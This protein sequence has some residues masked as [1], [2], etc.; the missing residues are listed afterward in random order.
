MNSSIPSALITGGCGFIG[1]RLAEHLVES[2]TRVTLL[3]NSSRA[4]LDDHA[5]SLLRHPLVH[6]L[7][8]DL[9]E[10]PLDDVASLTP[11]HVFHLAAIVGV[12]NV[13][14]RPLDVLRTNAVTTSRLIDVLRHSDTLQRLVFFSTS[15]VH[16]GTTAAGALAFPTP[17]EA[18]LIL[19][20]LHHPRSSY[21]LSKIYGEALVH[22]SGLPATVLRPHNVYGPRMGAAHVIPELI[23]RIAAAQ[24]RQPLTITSPQYTRSFCHV[25]DAVRQI[26][27]AAHS[28][29]AVGRTFN[30]GND[31]EEITMLS[32]ARRIADV[33]G[34]HPELLPGEPQPHSPSRRCPDMT[35][36]RD[37]TGVGATIPLTDGLRATAA[38]YTRP[39]AL[40]ADHPDLIAP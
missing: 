23:R 20:T 26:V 15:E 18:P 37:L 6:H 33:M 19:P 39:G 28:P 40:A 30:V 8:T 35:R 29:L 10:D 31:S 5:R 38:F 27:A 14:R 1:L 32:L 24:D 12:R 34:H 36:L 22:Q 3:D 21:A 4:P 16:L 25:D 2:G 9:A 11:T 7:G 13:E 17:E